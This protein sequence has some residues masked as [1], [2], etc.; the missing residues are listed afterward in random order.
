MSIPKPTT[1]ELAILQILWASGPN[2]ARYV[3]ESLNA[4]RD[5]SVV[6]TTVLKTMQTMA[7]KG[8]LLRDESA[9]SHIYRPAVN[10]ER[11]RR[12]MIGDLVSGLFAGSVKELVVNALGAGKV[13]RGELREIRRIIEEME[14]EP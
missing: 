6:Y 5:T 1:A 2:T 8:L 11:V 10:P 7:A 3:W 9:R 12:S 4:G 14:R 13:T